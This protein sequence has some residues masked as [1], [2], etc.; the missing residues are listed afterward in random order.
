MSGDTLD[1]IESTNLIILIGFNQNLASGG[2]FEA[3][4]NIICVKI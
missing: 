2:V 1:D 3:R 4:K